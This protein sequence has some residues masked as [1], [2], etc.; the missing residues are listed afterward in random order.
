MTFYLL[1]AIIY[2]YTISSCNTH[3]MLLGQQAIHFLLFRRYTQDQ[4]LYQVRFSRWILKE[5]RFLSTV[6]YGLMSEFLFGAHRLT[7]PMLLNNLAVANRLNQIQDQ[8]TSSS[9]KPAFEG[10]SL[11]LTFRTLRYHHVILSSTTMIG[12]VYFHIYIIVCRI[13]RCNHCSSC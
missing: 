1:L 11:S 12:K 6:H 2:Q 9:A 10:N 13:F 8:T 7:E 3:Q 4:I 5:L